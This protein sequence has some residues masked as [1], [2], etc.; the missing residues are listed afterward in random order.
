MKKQA[1]KILQE[2]E[3]NASS[4]LPTGICLFDP[5]WHQGVVGI[6]ASRIKEKYHRPVICFALANDAEDCDEL[7]GSARSIK[8]FHIRDALDRLQQKMRD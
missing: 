6:L 3:K 8:G 5:S 7:K 4:D 1:E 2:L